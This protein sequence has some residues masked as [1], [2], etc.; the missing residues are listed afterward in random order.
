MEFRKQ[1][2]SIE[3]V[4]AIDLVHYL[5]VHGHQPSKVRNNDYWYFSPLRDEKTPSFKVN[6]ILNRWYDHG[7]GEGGNLIDFAIL[8]HGC[9]VSELLQKLTAGFSFQE[10]FHYSISDIAKTENKII[11]TG[12]FILSSMPLLRYLEERRIPFHIAEKY[13][14]E[15]RFELKGKQ[16]YG[17]GFKNDYGG[18]EIRNPYFKSSSSPKD[19]TT[20][21]NGASEVCVFEGFIDFLS[22][23]TI[24]QIK[25]EDRFDFV[26][27]NSL[28]FFERALN[29]MEKHATTRLYLDRDKAGQNCSRFA[30]SLGDQYKDESLLYEHHKDLNDWLINFGRSERTYKRR[31]HK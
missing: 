9:T 14:R 21:D 15:V 6:K 24:H 8:Y 4:K 3:E 13:C 10:R 28:S 22:F 16:Y 5:G 17:I 11:I 27:L 1:L 20:I 7:I 2:L 26:I 25:S 19:I 29:F 18:Y 30:L 31:K 12:D 23:K